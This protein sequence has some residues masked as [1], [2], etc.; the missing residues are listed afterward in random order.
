[1]LLSIPPQITNQGGIMEDSM[2]LGSGKA[3]VRSV[4]YSLGFKLP[5]NFEERY[6]LKHK[7]DHS[8][9]SISFL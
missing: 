9:N 6:S 4:P 2:K 1:M 5:R 3:A 8:F 7:R